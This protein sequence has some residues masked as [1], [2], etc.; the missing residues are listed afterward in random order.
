M[1]QG[2]S[3]RF[4]AVVPC[5]EARLKEARARSAAPRT[6]DH[7]RDVPIGVRDTTQGGSGT[8]R[9]F[10]RRYKVA[11]SVLEWIEFV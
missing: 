1:I 2:V 9:S 7:S 4:V 10:C 8:A 5:A 3:E 11:P 6:R